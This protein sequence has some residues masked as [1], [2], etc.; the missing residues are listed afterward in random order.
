MRAC[1]ERAQQVPD[2][3]QPLGVAVVGMIPNI[4]GEGAA[5]IRNLIGINPVMAAVSAIIGNFLS[6]LTVV[7]VSFRVRVR[8][9]VRVREKVVTGR[10]GGDNES[11]DSAASAALSAQRAKGQCA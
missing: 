5:A 3:V 11:T 9:R 4:E 7:T 6:V 2:N 10:G 1:R 8:V